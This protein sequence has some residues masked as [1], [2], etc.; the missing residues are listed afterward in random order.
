MAT[1]RTRVLTPRQQA[2]CLLVASGVPITEAWVSSGH[3]KKIAHVQPWR[4]LQNP[5]IR[6]KIRAYQD[7][8]AK[9][10]GITVGSLLAEL[11]LTRCRAIALGQYA[12]AATATMGKAKLLGFLVDRIEDVTQR[13]PSLIPTKATEMT[14]QAW[15]K[16]VQN[17][18]PGLNTVGGTNGSG[19]GQAH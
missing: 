2:F 1:Q 4:T 16:M 7:Q 3:S 9:D 14:E 19:N 8:F 11:E 17:H 18:M 10:H 5:S 12:A 13:K 6:A 15:Q